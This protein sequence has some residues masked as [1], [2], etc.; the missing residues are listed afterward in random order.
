MSL[1]S[2]TVVDAVGAAW[3]PHAPPIAAAMATTTSTP[4]IRAKGEI[5]NLPSLYRFRAIELPRLQ[6]R[7]LDR[8]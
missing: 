6:T 7:I 1:M 3:L 8:C 5:L 4:V 2:A